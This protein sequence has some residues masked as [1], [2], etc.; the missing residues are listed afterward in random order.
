MLTVGELRK[1]I[2]DLK[3]DTMV[4]IMESYDPVE[5][6]A[7]YQECSEM[8][9]LPEQNGGAVLILSPFATGIVTDDEF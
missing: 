2:K 3:D 5:D 6:V 1:A 4:G 7:E 8:A 9:L